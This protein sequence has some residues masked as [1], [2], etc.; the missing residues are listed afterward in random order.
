MKQLRLRNIFY[1]LPLI[2]FTLT[3]SPN[4]SGPG[5]GIT[6]V[7]TILLFLVVGYIDFR[8]L[9]QTSSYLADA[10]AILVVL[11]SSWAGWERGHSFAILIITWPLLFLGRIRNTSLLIVI[12]IIQAITLF[13]LIYFGIN[14]YDFN[15]LLNMRMLWFM[16]VFIF[17]YLFISSYLVGDRGNL[18][19]QDRVISFILA[20]VSLFLY[21]WLM[22]EI[23]YALI[24]AVLSLPSFF[25]LVKLKNS[26]G[27]E[28]Q[29]LF[30]RNFGIFSII[31][32]T[33]FNFYLFI[34]TTQVLQAV[35]GGY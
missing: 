31:A 10:L 16:P 8:K 11:G 21:S 17:Q 24:L 3:G 7:V 19:R 2:F 6:L 25:I 29:N 5:I 13:C 1:P 12:S 4:F 20:V 34:D 14:Q 27:D 32:L 9:S 22:Y 26:G 15:N 30:F 18:V 35:M 33:I 23:K 28:K